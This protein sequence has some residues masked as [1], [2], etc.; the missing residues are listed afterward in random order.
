[1]VSSLDFLVMLF[2]LVGIQECVFGPV[3]TRKN[4]LVKLYLDF[5]PALYIRLSPEEAGV[6]YQHRKLSDN[7]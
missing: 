6:S 7:D 1:M 4:V 5:L 2:V 3:C